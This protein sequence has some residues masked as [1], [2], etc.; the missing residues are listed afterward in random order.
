M[1]FLFTD[2]R[3]VKQMLGI[4]ATDTSADFQI[5]FLIGIASE[6]I[7]EICGR[8]F[9]QRAVTEYYVGNG[10]PLLPLKRRPILLTPNPE[11]WMNTDGYFGAPSGSF[12]DD[13]KLTFGDDFC[14]D[15]DQDD[16]TS[17]RSG[18]LVYMKGVWPRAVSRKVGSLSPS[19]NPNSAM[20]S[21][22]VTYT[23]GFTVNT[24]PS[25]LRFACDI[26]V[27]RML[28]ILPLGMEVTS[29]SWQGRAV[30]PVVSEKSK[31]LA[32]AMPFLLPFKNWSW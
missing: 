21:I 10:T 31:L 32:L 18:M 16:G 28:T 24:L 25:Q 9:E 30:S 3:E 14:L 29:E 17:S 6:W 26:L 4:D 12:P 11:V 8:K 20:G 23:A 7:E 27:G 2:L 22:K 15:I 1:A 19:F 13:D 5:S